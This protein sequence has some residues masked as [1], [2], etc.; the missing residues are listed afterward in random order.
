[1][2]LQN[3]MDERKFKNY[4]T[5]L[6]CVGVGVGV[7]GVGGGWA[8][9]SVWQ[10]VKAVDERETF[11]HIF[12][13]QEEEKKNQSFLVVVGVFCMV[14]GIKQSKR[15]FCLTKHVK[16]NLIHQKHSSRFHHWFIY[17]F[18]NLYSSLIIHNN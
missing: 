1:M 8:V 18:N 15:V 7:G 2:T 14:Y 12:N 3:S 13:Q 17:Y 11:K 6:S 10:G 16:W 4:H 9:F 5:L